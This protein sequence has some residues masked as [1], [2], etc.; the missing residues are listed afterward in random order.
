MHHVVMKNI[1]GLATL[2]QLRKSWDERFT[3]SWGLALGVERLPGVPS[4]P[5]VFFF[6]FVIES[7]ARL[8][9]PEF[10]TRRKRSRTFAVLAEANPETFL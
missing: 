4:F 7:A 2:D 3:T 8:L 1:D 9:R 10:R 6:F 5:R